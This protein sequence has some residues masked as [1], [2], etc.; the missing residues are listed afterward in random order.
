MRI[1]SHCCPF[2]LVLE[3]IRNQ[4]IA[5]HS[6][7][8]AA[9]TP[10]HQGGLIAVK[11]SAFDVIRHAMQQQQGYR[12]LWRGA[13]MAVARDGIGCGCFFVTMSWTQNQLTRPGEAPT[14]PV[15]MACGAAAGLSFW[16]AALPLDTVKTWIQSADLTARAP[17]VADTVRQILAER[18][19]AGLAQRLL[20]GWQVAYGRGMPSAAL[21]LSVYSFAY[22]QL[23]RAN[24]TL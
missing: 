7:L 21:T 20:S 1:V 3:L 22:H 16:L 10:H 8:A 13:S 4:L 12:S 15:T 9:A 11:R 18:G 2:F 19:P 23:A 14:L 17:R 5:Q 6:K 24:E